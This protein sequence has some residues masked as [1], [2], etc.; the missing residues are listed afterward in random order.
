M[1]NQT[2]EQKKQGKFIGI[3]RSAIFE[4]LLFF[5]VIFLLAFIWNRGYNFSLLCPHPFWI[6]VI[7]ISTQY[8]TVEGLLAAFVSTVIYLLG[9][10]D[11]RSLLQDR[12]EYFFVIANTP[13]QWFI[14][15]VLLGELRLKHKRIEDELR[16]S[17]L[18][19]EK[20]EQRVAETYDS[21]KK[22]KERLEMRIAS[23]MHTPLM[24]MSAFKQLDS[25]NLSNLSEGAERLIKVLAEP[26]KF[27]IFLFQEAE[28]HC[29]IKSGW[30]TANEF[31][32]SF[33][34][35][36]LIYQSVKEKKVLSVFTSDLHLLNKEGILIVPIIDESTDLA[37]GMIKVEQIEFYKIRTSLIETLKIIGYWIGKSYKETIEYRETHD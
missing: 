30:K 32:E 10:L 6:A 5:I 24:T 9:P 27:S 21:L 4:I 2:H 35:D 31:T 18:E 36:S 29:V 28:L 19:S 34:S 3:R 25:S 13:I 7:L 20:K 8:G 22:I 37:F 26:E 23:N 33:K 14:A 1:D 12:S 11:A 16:Q 17:V 15:A